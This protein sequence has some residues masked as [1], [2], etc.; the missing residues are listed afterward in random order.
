MTRKGMLVE[1]RNVALTGTRQELAL[2]LEDPDEWI[3]PD[4]EPLVTARPRRE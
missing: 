2:Y 1:R 3:N 4:I